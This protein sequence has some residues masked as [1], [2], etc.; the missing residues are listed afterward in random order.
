[1]KY[2]RSETGEVIEVKGC[3]TCPHMGKREVDAQSFMYC[4]VPTLRPDGK[5]KPRNKKLIGRWTGAY[6][7]SCPLASAPENVPAVKGVKK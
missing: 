6:H 5:R 3:T 4:V 1:M 7:E 2:T